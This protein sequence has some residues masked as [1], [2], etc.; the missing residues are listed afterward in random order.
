MN[1]RAN[2]T[3]PIENLKKTL[4]VEVSAGPKKKAFDFEPAFRD[5]V[6]IMHPSIQQFR[7]HIN[8]D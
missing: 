2:G 4:K 5:Q 1:S 3:T 8:I 6:I 7:L